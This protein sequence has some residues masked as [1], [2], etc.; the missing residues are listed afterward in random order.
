MP[1]FDFTE[2]EAL[3]RIIAVDTAVVV[4]R[5]DDLDRLRRVQVNRLVAIRSSRRGRCNDRTG[6]HRNLA[7]LSASRDC[8]VSGRP[9]DRLGLGRRND[10]QRW[11]RPLRSDLGR[12]HRFG[13]ELRPAPAGRCRSARQHSAVQKKKNRLRDLLLNSAPPKTQVSTERGGDAKKTAFV[14]GDGRSIVSLDVV[15]VNF[16]AFPVSN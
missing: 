1:I 5:I 15:P 12:R 3:G 7:L 13:L 4:V 6:Q 8:Q 14:L 11:H 9:R 10:G 2:A 16:K